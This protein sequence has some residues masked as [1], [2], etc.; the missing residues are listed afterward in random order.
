[1]A[2][3]K[4]KSHAMLGAVQDRGPEGAMYDECI[5]ATEGRLGDW[6]LALG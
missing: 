4:R 1:M 2:G 3:P 5:E 6:N